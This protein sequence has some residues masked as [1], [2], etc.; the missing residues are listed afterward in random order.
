MFSCIKGK[1]EC[2]VSASE[3]KE[4]RDNKRKMHD[5]CQ[6]QEDVDNY[7][8]SNLIAEVIYHVCEYGKYS[9]YMDYSHIYNKRVV[10][11][12]VSILNEKGFISKIGFCSTLEVEIKE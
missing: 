9:Q 8:A 12:V 7:K 10:E 5:S 6:T 2:V 11:K 4:Y 1:L 3:V